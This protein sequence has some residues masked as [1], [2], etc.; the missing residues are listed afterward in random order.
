MKGTIL[1]LGGGGFSMSE[2]GS[3]LIDDFLLDMANKKQPK[4]CFIPTASGDADEYSEEFLQAFSHRADT[5]VLS[6]FSHD[7]WGYTP[8][9]MLLDQD[10]IY[11]GGGSTA[12]LL[13]VWRVH[14]VPDILARAAADGVILAGISAGMIH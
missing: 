2:D 13:A 5:S 11:V 8:P 3:S 4:V 7:P 9:A 12:N 14:D 6:L 10:I 1:T